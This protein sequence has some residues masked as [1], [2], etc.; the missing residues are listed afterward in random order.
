LVQGIAFFC[1]A[2]GN[3]FFFGR[4]RQVAVFGTQCCMLNVLALLII[5]AHHRMAAANT[6]SRSIPSEDAC[7][8]ASHHF[9]QR[10]ALP[11]TEP[12]PCHPIPLRNK[13][14]E[15]GT[16]IIDKPGIYVVQEDII[17]EPITPGHI[18]LPTCQKY[19]KANGYWLGFFAAIAIA[20][21]DVIIDLNGHS[22]SMSIKFAFTQRFFSIIQLG[23]KPFLASQGPPQFKSLSVDPII[24]NRVEIKN[25]V[26]GLSTHMGIHGNNNYGVTVNDLVIKDFETGG[27]QL[28]GAEQVKIERVTIGPSM[29]APGSSIPVP[30][31][32]TLSQSIFLNNIAQEFQERSPETD[33]L[34]VALEEFWD[35]ST[36]GKP[37][38][39]LSYYLT[40]PSYY[41]GLPDGSALYGILLHKSG[42]AIHEFGACALSDMAQ[43][44]SDPLEGFEI[45]DVVIKDL[46][47]KSDEV[48]KMIVANK[49]VLGP[50]GDVVQ[51][52]RVMDSHQNYKGTALSDA[53]R[54]MME[55]RMKAQADG[56]SED[57]QFLRYGS[58]YIPPKLL[59]WMHGRERFSKAI[60]GAT[61]ECGGDS[62]S[63]VNKGVVAL[64]VEFVNDVKLENISVSGLHN[65][66]LRSPAKHM[67]INKKKKKKKKQSGARYGGGDVWVLAASDSDDRLAINAFGKKNITFDESSLFSASGKVHMV[68]RGPAGLLG[69]PAGSPGGADWSQ[70]V[71][72]NNWLR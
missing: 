23:S 35:T 64:R 7:P 53:Q 67:C 46:Y 60:A 36:E 11:P 44:D 33:A 4:M 42:V 70:K 20:A 22:I 39:S 55:N 29:G 12:Q 43:L 34:K 21:D 54:R 8:T 24:A 68:P 41:G 47:L 45:K 2:F 6:K 32:A 57:D 62:M 16:Y 56:M 50:A 72:A 63:H 69:G 26:L 48:V 37:P 52:M 38:T 51:V 3:C 27:I 65:Y 10:T 19:S 5:F 25:G 1:F 14:F 17:F 59:D 49:T 61:W 71:L 30:A 58:T 40:D 18:P 13:D 28:N 9:I 15:P 31:L 66:G